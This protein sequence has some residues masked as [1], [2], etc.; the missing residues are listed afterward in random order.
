MNEKLQRLLTSVLD[1]VS[2]GKGENEQTNKII[3]QVE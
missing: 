1:G 2:S 3:E